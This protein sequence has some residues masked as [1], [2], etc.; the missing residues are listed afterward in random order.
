MN[1]WVVAAVA[2]VIDTKSEVA[3]VTP[4]RTPSKWDV[5]FM[6]R[7]AGVTTHN[8]VGRANVMRAGT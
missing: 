4:V 6:E 8:Y 1:D 3:D 2:D 7:G 5:A